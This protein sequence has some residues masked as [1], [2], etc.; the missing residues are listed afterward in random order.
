MDLAGGAGVPCG[1]ARQTRGHSSYKALQVPV[2]GPSLGSVLG[3]DT[4]VFPAP[5]LEPGSEQ[6]LL[7]YLVR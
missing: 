1:M 4:L 7:K 5:H 2:Q 6:A 3:S